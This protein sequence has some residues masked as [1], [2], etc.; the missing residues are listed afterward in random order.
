M[1]FSVSAVALA[2][3]VFLLRWRQFSAKV[4]A[5]Y[6]LVACQLG[7]MYLFVFHAYQYLTVAEFLLL[8]Y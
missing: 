4:I 2:S 1:V 5:L 6:M 7:I 8:R 3:L